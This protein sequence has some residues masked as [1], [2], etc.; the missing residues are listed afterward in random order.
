MTRTTVKA[1]HLGKPVVW[2]VEDITHFS[3]A[4]KYVTAH[5]KDGRELLLTDTIKELVND[6]G[7]QFIE[8]RRGMLV[9]RELLVSVQ[10]SREKSNGIAVVWG[11]GNLPC[12]RARMP[13][14]R[15]FLRNRCMQ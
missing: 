1:L 12:S 4:D 9:R 10:S 8:I 13:G 14:L 6:L 11:I 5:H 3:H 15:S 7:D 2:Q